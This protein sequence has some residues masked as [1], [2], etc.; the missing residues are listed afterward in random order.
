MLL[1]SPAPKVSSMAI[2]I[3]SIAN[4]I[5]AE[6]ARIG[7]DTW[8]SIKKSAPVYVKGYV[9]SIVQISAG[10]RSGEI[11]RAEARIYVENSKLL[12]AQAIANTAHILLVQVQR[13]I[14]AVI[15]ALKTAINGVLPVA[16]L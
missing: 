5:L 14:N 13:L 3:N 11:S 1:T 6:A 4:S 16:V 8:T 12:L 15:G 10:V 7:G 2:N 9:Q